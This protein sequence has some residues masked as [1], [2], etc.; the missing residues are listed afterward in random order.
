MMARP[1]RYDAHFLVDRTWLNDN[2][3]NG[4]FMLLWH[5]TQRNAQLP[6]VWCAP[7][8]NQPGR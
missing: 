2:C 4:V 3:V 5:R 7:F 1:Q 8:P 6:R